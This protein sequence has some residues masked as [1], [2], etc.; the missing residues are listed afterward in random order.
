M[1]ARFAHLRQGRML[2]MLD[3]IASTATVTQ[4]ATVPKARTATKKARGTA[5]PNSRQQDAA[6]RKSSL[7]DTKPFVFLVPGGGL[8]PPRPCGLR[9]L[10]PF[11]AIQHYPASHCTKPNNNQIMNDMDLLSTSHC[12]APKCTKS[13]YKVAPKAA[14]EF[15]RN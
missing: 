2:S 1:S 8:E 14:P 4:T 10:S 7:D 11:L 6:I 13:R 15:H 12:V 9:I 5:S 3:R